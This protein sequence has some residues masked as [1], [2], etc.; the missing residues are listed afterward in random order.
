MRR[1]YAPIPDKEWTAEREAAFFASLPKSIPP[2]QS[3]EREALVRQYAG[4]T[5]GA[6]RMSRGYVDALGAVLGTFAEADRHGQ[7]VRLSQRMAQYGSPQTLRTIQSQMAGAGLLTK[8]VRSQG[9]GFVGTVF[10]YKTP[11]PRWLRRRDLE[12]AIERWSRAYPTEALAD[13]GID[14]VPF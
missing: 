5:L 7:E 8:D 1:K 2:V 6:L 12:A 4:E 10:T 3:K 9:G 14:E 13:L 11:K